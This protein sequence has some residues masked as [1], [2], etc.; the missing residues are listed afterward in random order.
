MQI[1]YFGLSSFKLASKNYT[2][3]TDPF[4]KSSGLTPPRGNADLLILAEKENPLY[5]YTQSISGTPFIVDGPGEY[6][7]K[8]HAI[9]GI[10]IKKD[11]RLIT[12]YLMEIEGIKI[13]NLTHIKKLELT[14]DELEDLGEVDILIVP[15]GNNE[16]MDY[17]TAAKAANLI[18]PKIIIPSHY[19]TG[20]LKIPA[21][22]LE[23]F[24]KE[25]GG[26]H[27]NAEK[28]NIKK[29]DL[30]EEAVKIMVL[31]PMR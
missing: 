8:E 5:S 15:V 22:N 2:S 26:K 20:G 18:E 31:E 7:V 17:E 23:K 29:K 11:G 10:P 3:I 25:M 21:D 4:D 19:Q 9:T 28:L 14:Q 27:E 6:D 13:L 16:V 1:S 24:L 30:T 12:I